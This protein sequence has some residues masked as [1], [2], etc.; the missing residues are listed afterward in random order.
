MRDL[1][2]FTGQQSLPTIHSSRT[3]KSHSSPHAVHQT[4]RRGTKARMGGGTDSNVEM[5]VGVG[6]I[7]SLV[8]F[9]YYQNYIISWH[10]AKLLKH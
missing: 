7:F 10:T 5:A 1:Q 8:I 9:F 6:A 4:S 2:V 3:R